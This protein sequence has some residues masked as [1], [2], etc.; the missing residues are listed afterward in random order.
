MLSELLTLKAENEQL[1]GRLFERDQQINSLRRN[2]DS[3]TKEVGRQDIY[4]KVRQ[5]LQQLNKNIAQ[6]FRPLKSLSSK[7]VYST[8]DLLTVLTN[9]NC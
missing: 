4:A 6:T 8:K 9:L 3:E 7:E 5:E 1:R 2:D